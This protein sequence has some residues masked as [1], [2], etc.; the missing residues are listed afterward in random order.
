M[1]YAD[2]ISKMKLLSSTILLLLVSLGQAS[3]YVPGTPGAV[4]SDEEVRV[5]RLKILE[6]LSLDSNKMDEM[7]PTRG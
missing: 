2:C 7:F 4:W 3:E 5:V 6:L 1:A